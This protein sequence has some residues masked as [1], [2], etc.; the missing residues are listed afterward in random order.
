LWKAQEAASLK[1][2]ICFTSGKTPILRYYDLDRPA[3]VETDASDFVIEAVLSQNFN[4]GKI[5]PIR[6]LSRKSNPTEFN[7]DIYN[8][9]MLPVIWGFE[10]WRHF[11]QSAMYKTIVYSDH[12]NLT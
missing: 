1:T 2:V 12:P 11:L 7:Y 4:V 10:K 6:F 3:L 8:K 9:Y 5:H